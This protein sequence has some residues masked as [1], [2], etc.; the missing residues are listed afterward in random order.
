MPYKDPQKND[1]CKRR[2]ALEHG[3]QYRKENRAQIIEYRRSR[4][5]KNREYRRQWDTANR[6]KRARY[7]RRW[8]QKNPEYQKSRLRADPEFRLRRVLRSRL[9]HALKSVGAKRADRTLN[10]LGCS[11]AHLKAWLTFYFQ[12]GMSWNNYGEWHVD[13]IRPCVSFDLTDSEQQKECFHYTNL[14]P[15]WK[16]DNFK[17]G[18]KYG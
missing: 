8:R 17:K 3:A 16:L 6:E 7:F 15:L 5:V 18:A 10:L 2:W 13:H 1:E 4:L 11:P 12:P 9:S 14:Q